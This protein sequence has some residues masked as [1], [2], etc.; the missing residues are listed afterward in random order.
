MIRARRNWEHILRRFELDE[1]PN[2]F[3]VLLGEMSLVGPRPEQAHYV[4]QFPNNSP[5][6][7]GTTSREGGNDWLGAS[8]RHAR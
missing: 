4:E 3:N 2:L 1:L 8:E 5:S 7:Y 6:L